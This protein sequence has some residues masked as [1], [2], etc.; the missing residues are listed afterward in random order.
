MGSLQQLR[1]LN[2]QRLLE[3]LRRAGAGDRAGLAHHTG[4]S[5]T[6]VSALVNECL[7]DGV[8]LEEAERP[9]AN[10]RGRRTGRLRLNPLAGAVVGAD[11]GHRHLRVAVADLTALIVAEEAIDLDVDA[12]PEAALDAAASLVTRLLA[13]AGVTD[14]RV[15]GIGMGLPAPIDRSSGTVGASSILP[16]WAGIRPGEAITQRLGFPVRL[17]NDA[18]LGALSEFTY[19]AGRTVSDLVYVKV[20]SGIGAGLVLEG[21]LHSGAVGLAGELGHVRVVDD[22]FVCRCGNRGCLE[23]VASAGALIRAHGSDLG[24]AEILRL[25]AE[26]DA[27]AAAVVQSAGRHLGRALALL[28]NAIDPAV[29]VIGGELGAGSALLR[30]TVAGELRRSALDHGGRIPVEAATLGERAEL[31]GALA[32]ALSEPAWLAGAGLVSLDGAAAV[33]S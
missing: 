23:T 29:V 26:G 12:D 6:T 21:V 16:A 20:A 1:K 28:C 32:L 27:R 4:L 10:R 9:V 22:G 13:E 5:R 19:G 11:F 30:R 14:G 18:N 33:A 2:R 17:E 7:A 3:E 24:A 15:L 25:A 31:L 8:I